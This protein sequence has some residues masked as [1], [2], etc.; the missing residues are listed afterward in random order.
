MSISVVVP[1]LNPEKAMTPS[2]LKS[3]SNEI[4]FSKKKGIAKARNYGAKLS[5]GN[6]LIFIDD[7][8]SINIQTFNFA[9]KTLTQ[10]PKSIICTEHPI[11]CSRFMALSKN[12]FFDIGG[13]DET[14]VRCE[15]LD[16]GYRAIRK[17]YKI[18]YIPFNKVKHR[19]HE[20]ARPAI[21]LLRDASYKTRL[22][23]R[24]KECLFHKKHNYAS[25]PI[26]LK[27]VA[28]FFIGVKGPR[29]I[30]NFM[31]LYLKIISFYYYLF[32]DKKIT[33]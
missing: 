19:E 30:W 28:L 1:S 33:L 7:D 8:T 6:V 20:G 15:D 21:R 25:R 12:V 32:F 18:H 31:S 4:I 9:I 23:I 27:N 22:M 5:K 24:Y 16:F 10:N 2:F 26:N 11:L 14:F 17:G 29:I 13:F 3:Y